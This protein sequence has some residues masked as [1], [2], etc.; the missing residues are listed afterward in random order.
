MLPGT[1]KWPREYP[2]VRILTAG[3]SCSVFLGD[4]NVK[5]LWRHISSWHLFMHL[6]LNQQHFTA[7]LLAFW[8]A[9]RCTTDPKSQPDLNQKVTLRLY[10]CECSTK[11]KITWEIASRA[12]HVLK[13]A[14]SS[15][16]KEAF[17]FYSKQE[18][19]QIKWCVLLCSAGMQ[20]NRRAVWEEKDCSEATAQKQ[21]FCISA[22][23]QGTH[24]PI[25]LPFY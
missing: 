22:G 13:R 9:I 15:D 17:V 12:R 25:R 7:L 11:G 6:G 14:T 5:P 23:Q 21:R 10:C 19:W 1:S 16:K 3:C 20:S 24:T 8:S 4:S 2:A 18:L